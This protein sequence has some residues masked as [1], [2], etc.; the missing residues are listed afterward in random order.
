MNNPSKCCEQIEK[1]IKEYKEKMESTYDYA[2]YETFDNVIEDLE[3][4]LYD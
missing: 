3:K 4:I 1:L 2:V